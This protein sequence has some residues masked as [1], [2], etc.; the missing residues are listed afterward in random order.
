MSE[1]TLL[2]GSNRPRRIFS[3]AVALLASWCGIH[4]HQ[5]ARAQT[6]MGEIQ[7]R[8]AP[9]YRCPGLPCG[10]RNV[11]NISVAVH[12]SPSAADLTAIRNMIS[13][14]SG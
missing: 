1:G 2:K 8:P 9:V 13:D 6:A 7:G 4:S 5:T 3:L 10:D 14:A 12:Y 11:F